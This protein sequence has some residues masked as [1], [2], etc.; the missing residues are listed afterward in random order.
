MR[1]I[2]ETF[3]KWIWTD[4]ERTDRLVALYNERFNSDRERTDDGSYL[5]FAGMDAGF[6]PWKHQR[7]MVAMSVRSPAVLC[8]YTMGAG[9]TPTA[10]MTAMKLRELGFA[11]KPLIIVPN[12]ILETHAAE[13]R[14]L[15]PGARILM[16]TK[17]DLQKG[18]RQAFTAKVA[19]TDWDCVV[20]THEQFTS[21]PMS[22]AV[23]EQFVLKQIDELTAAIQGHPELDGSRIS[24]GIAKQI[25]KLKARVGELRHLKRGR[26]TGLTL[27]QLGIDYLLV[28]E[29]HFFM[30]LFAAVRMEGFSMPGS[31][32]AWHLYMF[33]EWLRERNP[34]GRR[35]TA[36]TGTP[37]TNTLAEAYTLLRFTDPELLER[38]G[39]RSFDAFAGMYITYESK[40]EVAPDGSGFRMHRRPSKFI[41][42]PELR[43]AIRQRATVRSRKSLKLAG[44]SHVIRENRLVPQ[45][46]EL[47]GFI[48]LLVELADKIR[49]GI[50][51]PEKGA[52]NMLTVCNDGRK[53]SLDVRLV[54]IEPHD[55]DKV[56]EAIENIARLWHHHKDDVFPSP[57]SDALFDLDGGR[58]GVC[59]LVFCDLG[60]PN[61]DGNNVYGRIRRG[62]IERGVPAGLIAFGHEAKT[63]EEQRQLDAR[64]NDGRT[65]V[66]ITSLAK[67]GTGRNLQ[68]R[69]RHVHYLTPPWRPDQYEQ[70][71]G[72]AVRPGNLCDI[73]TIW[74]YA[75]E[76]SFDPFMWQAL[77]RKAFFIAQ[78]FYGDDNI[79]EVEEIHSEQVLDFAQL[80]AISTGQEDV[81][82]LA[83]ADAEVA[84][85]Q[86]EW[87]HHMRDRSRL[88]SEYQMCTSRAGSAERAHEVWTAIAGVVAGDPARVLNT[89]TH[90]VEDEEKAAELIAAA[91]REV[92]KGFG[93]LAGTWRGVE[94]RFEFEWF[95]T[96]PRLTVSLTPPKMWRGKV[97]VDIS[98]KLARPGREMELLAAVDR[99]INGA[100]M[101]ANGE[102][103]AR[104]RAQ[105]RADEIKPHLNAS[106]PL[107]ADLK[108]ALACRDDLRE[109]IEKQMHRPA[110]RATEAAAAA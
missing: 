22:P 23:E 36:Y 60:T 50:I 17:E 9:K 1:K 54:G 29:F 40:I 59:Q 44:P 3:Q 103:A 61:K 67:G 4:P 70:G 94:V 88:K 13:G 95:G 81:M 86:N 66:I 106:F 39:L 35:L 110:Q 21:I 8:G 92:R 45:P 84:R 51:K 10:Y 15:F 49:S 80:M 5:T 52:P 97:H 46:T 31:K 105:N 43:A 90:T 53:A 34:G 48:S 58:T 107:E 6:S 78:L 27:D 64:C 37:V 87:S 77:T 26:D 33:L 25:K 7:D 57:D 100:A 18:R 62:L 42:V 102:A 47:G 74:R 65:Q 83:E 11:R 75:T 89:Y 99:A 79:R 28:D 30:R 69:L 93:G 108:A 96:K 56:D 71:E 2:Q 12:H 32:R 68:E 38:Q 55:D 72:R 109:R 20:M 76:A 14:R 91:A 104:V 98:A 16:V 85:L 73:V 82:R 41:N 24:K 101:E 19:G 63:H